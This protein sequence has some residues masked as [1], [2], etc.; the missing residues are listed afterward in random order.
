MLPG[1]SLTLY[2]TDEQ[3]SVT[4]VFFPSSPFCRSGCRFAAAKYCNMLL[5]DAPGFPTAAAAAQFIFTDLQLDVLSPYNSSPHSLLLPS[6][7]PPPPSVCL[8]FHV[9]SLSEDKVASSESVFI[10]LSSHFV[11]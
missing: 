3:T 8:C 7:L 1:D 2:L 9:S 10:L 6:F 4:A 5:G 11:A